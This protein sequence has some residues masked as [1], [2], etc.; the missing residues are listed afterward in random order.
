MLPAQGDSFRW[1]RL[2]VTVAEMRHRRI[3]KLRVRLLEEESAE[4]GAEA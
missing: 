4:G 3:L 1:H 2:Q